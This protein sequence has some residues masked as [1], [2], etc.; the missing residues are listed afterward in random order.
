VIK[1]GICGKLSEKGT[2]DISPVIYT[3]N[4]YAIS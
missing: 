4:N 3:E 2:N 1:D